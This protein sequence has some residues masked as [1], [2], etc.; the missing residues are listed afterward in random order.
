MS[1]SERYLDHFSHP[2]GVGEVADPTC[3]CEVQH[4]GGGCF[5][6]VKLTVKLDGDRISEVKFRARAC[7]GTIAALS[8]MVEVVTGLDV[9]AARRVTSADLIEFL[10]GIPDKKQHSVVL[11]ARAIVECLGT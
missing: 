9:E 4:E 10:G 3:A 5:D 6:K 2:R 1:L 8:A 7:S 11:A